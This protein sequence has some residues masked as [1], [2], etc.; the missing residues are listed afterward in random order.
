MRGIVMA[1]LS[2]GLLA[3]HGPQPARSPQLTQ[4][5]LKALIAKARKEVE[6]DEQ[7]RRAADPTSRPTVPGSAQDEFE[8]RQRGFATYECP[9]GSGRRC[10][11]WDPVPWYYLEPFK[12]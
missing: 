4:E 8:W 5:E 6:A 9:D 11:Y 3:C 12:D 7:A 10:H 1:T 2:L